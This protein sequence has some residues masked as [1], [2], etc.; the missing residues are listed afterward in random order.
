M[1]RKHR[2]TYSYKRKLNVRKSL[3]VIFII[4]AGLLVLLWTGIIDPGK[5]VRNNAEAEPSITADSS[6][7]PDA[8]VSEGTLPAGSTK[9]SANEET[10]SS[11]GN[12][13]GDTT[14]SATETSTEKPPVSAENSS[15]DNTT[16][17]TTESASE[18][19][20][21]I[22]RTP[23]HENMPLY[24]SIPAHG[25]TGLLKEQ[26]QEMINGFSGTYGITFVNLATGERIGI[27][28]T[29]EYIAASTSKF[30]MNVL[31]W[32]RV[33]AGEIDPEMMLVYKQE[34]F[35]SGTG[36]IQAEP[37]GT[38]YSVR[39]T[40]KYSIIHSDNCGINM[41]IRLLNIEDIRQYLRDLGGVV[42]YGARHRS[43]PSDMA[44][45]AVDLY[46]FY[47]ENPV[48]AGEL[49]EYLENTDWNDRINLSLP[50]EI[51]VAHKIGNQTKTANDVGVIFASEPYVLSVMTDNVDFGAACKNIA[52][53]SKMIYNFLEESP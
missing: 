49:I 33:A 3:P 30:P 41:I 36:I 4:S 2:Q 27:N 21:L 1:N 12:S 34:D 16:E 8:N 45:V 35:E 48:I 31:L 23:G 11:E 20:S 43:C 7:N 50:K 5:W 14:D 6:P 13:A 42:E 46:Q 28:D 26:I 18:S 38:E 44:N 53:L 40:S 15:T 9:D 24:A 29:S 39:T 51:K 17:L 22:E 52:E 10:G 19:G 32:K 25:N 47:Y 37:F